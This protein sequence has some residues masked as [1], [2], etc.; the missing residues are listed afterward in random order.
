MKL[1]PGIPIKIGDKLVGVINIDE[2]TFIDTCGEASLDVL[3]GAGDLLAIAIKSA[4][5]E[6]EIIALSNVQS[7]FISSFPHELRIPISVIKEAVSMLHDEVLGKINDGQK[8]VLQSAARNVERLWRLSE[9]LLELSAI[10]AAKTPLKRKL[11][12]ITGLA[13]CVMTKYSPAAK[14]KGVRLDAERAQKKIEIWGDE[15]KLGIA[16]GN[17]IDNAIKYTGSGGGVSVRFEDADEKVS[18]IVSDMGAGI[19]PEDLDRVLDKFYR[20]TMRAKGEARKWGIG[21]PVV[22]E[23]VEMH[24]GNISIESDIGKGS[25]FTITLPKN[26]RP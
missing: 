22:K 20:V 2:K 14:E 18:L 7:D 5:L 4:G 21:L 1:I 25:K 10:A 23:I 12:D 11:F 9:E 8:K 15:E 17:L 16:I 3:K 19:S 26:L 6:R 13:A 24:H